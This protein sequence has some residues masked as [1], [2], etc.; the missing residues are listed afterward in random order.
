MAEQKQAH[1]DHLQGL[2]KQGQQDNCAYCER[3]GAR[4]HRKAAARG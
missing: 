3:R 2:H 4:D 1:T